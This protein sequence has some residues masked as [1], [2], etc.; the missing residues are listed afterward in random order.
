MP[1]TPWNPVLIE[2]YWNV[3]SG[4][5]SGEYRPEY[6]INRN[7]LECKEVY[8][9]LEPRLTWVLIETYWNVK[10]ISGG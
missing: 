8:A 4:R 10:E 1:K 7:I 5:S 6:R 9:T 3:K 2:T